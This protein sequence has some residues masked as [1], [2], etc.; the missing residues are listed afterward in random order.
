MDRRGVYRDDL[1]A[2]GERAAYLERSIARCR[3]R[4]S[5]GA[6]AEMG[7]LA[8]QISVAERDL[9]AAG[10]EDPARAH[11]RV[12]T[13]L[14]LHEL[15]KQAVI[16][17]PDVEGELAALPDEAP[18]PDLLDIPSPVVDLLYDGFTSDQSVNSW[19]RMQ[20]AADWAE[21][22]PGTLRDRSRR[23]ILRA[24][25]RTLD[26]PFFVAARGGQ[27]IRTGKA[28]ADVPSQ[29]VVTTAVARG[30]PELRVSPEELRHT[31][32][33]KPLRLVRDVEVCG[34]SFDGQF[35]VDAEEADARRL[36]TRDVQDAMLLIA[37]QD[38]PHLVIRPPVAYMYWNFEL[39]VRG[40]AAAVEALGA[41]RNAPLEL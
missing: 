14:R 30:A 1:R 32:L 7:G 10:A 17:C 4:V 21:A 6:L 29:V 11:D 34:P 22:M 5:A 3:S 16:L 15:Y 9:Q 23:R 35:L 28:E 40:V 37:R 39:T 12:A 27:I 31:L 2:L 24:T 26:G 25:F 19:D 38:I 18:D 41:I 20:E 13:L 36:L 33:L 8:D